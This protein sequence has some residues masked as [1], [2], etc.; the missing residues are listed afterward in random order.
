MWF[1][2]AHEP[3]DP[4]QQKE[5]RR[6]L[7]DTPEPCYGADPS[8]LHGVTN[9]LGNCHTPGVREGCHPCK[10]HQGERCKGYQP[11]ETLPGAAQDVYN[12][13]IDSPRGE[14]DH[15]LVIGETE[16]EYGI[17]KDAQ[18]GSP[19]TGEARGSGGIE[20][21]WGIPNGASCTPGTL[22]PSKRKPKPK[23]RARY[24]KPNG[25]FRFADIVLVNDRKL[26]IVR[27]AMVYY[28]GK[29]NRFVRVQVIYDKPR[30]DD[31]NYRGE[32]DVCMVDCFSPTGEC[33]VKHLPTSK[34]RGLNRQN[35][36]TLFKQLGSIP[37]G[38]LGTRGYR[39]V[40]VMDKYSDQYHEGPYRDAVPRPAW[41][42][43][44]EEPLRKP[45]FRRLE[46]VFDHD[47]EMIYGF[48]YNSDGS[49][50]K[51]LLKEYDPKE[52]HVL[53]QPEGVQDENYPQFVEAINAS[54]WDQ[55]HPRKKQ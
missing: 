7:G 41:T 31:V 55:L 37:E 24:G 42:L 2:H 47:P 17:P 13:R 46:V 11:Y 25:H 3:A 10:S 23:P 53:D 45:G 14:P 43:S 15:G 39:R 28:Q 5:I 27:K 33:N 48:D 18:P 6:R 50:V 34:I 35:L 9:S 16:T 40:M 38:L 49:N 19:C 4:T 20:R 12:S 51:I 52:T 54:I 36:P 44:R 30:A 29:R 8:L 22:P 1:S 32:K 26:G 21:E